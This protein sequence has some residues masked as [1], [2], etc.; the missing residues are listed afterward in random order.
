M[1]LIEIP[2]LAGQDYWK[3]VIICCAVY[4]VMKYHGNQTYM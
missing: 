2:S 4:K 1:R 3:Y